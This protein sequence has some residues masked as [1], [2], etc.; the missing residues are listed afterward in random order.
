[1]AFWNKLF[2]YKAGANNIGDMIH[3]TI[4]RIAFSWNANNHQ[5]AIYQA[6]QDKV[7]DDRLALSYTYAQMNREDR[8]NQIPA[9]D[10]A[11][12]ERR[13][14][15]EE[16]VWAHSH[17][18]DKYKQEF[19]EEDRRWA[20]EGLTQ[21]E[22]DKRRISKKDID[23]NLALS[24]KVLHRIELF[25]ETDIVVYDKIYGFYTI[26][27]QGPYWAPWNRPIYRWQYKGDEATVLYN[28]KWMPEFK[29]LE[30]LHKDYVMKKREQHVAE[31][32]KQEFLEETKQARAE[33]AE[34][35]RQKEEYEIMQKY[36]QEQNKRP[37]ITT[38]RRRDDTINHVRAALGQNSS[39]DNGLLDNSIF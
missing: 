2:E 20:D 6:M 15:S 12:A 37:R 5:K 1:M 7:H 33:L 21:T 16:D 31:L 8:F 23:R 35:T 34:F 32:R 25:D 14:Q 13:F 3:Y 24:T 4:S 29:H 27:I 18:L 26:E 22:I 10:V 36:Q 38:Y 17:C 39:I 28:V 9:T 19:L 30:Q 11:L